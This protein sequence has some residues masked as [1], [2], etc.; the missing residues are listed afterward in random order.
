MLSNLD[1][2]G[3]P[4]RLEGEC[5]DKKFLPIVAR[6]KEGISRI[7]V[8][9][10]DF[11]CSNGK[12]PLK[13]VVGKTMHL[14]A[15]SDD[16]SKKRWF[17]GTCVSAEF[18]GGWDVG[19]HYR[20]EVCP[21]L[22]F[23][24]RRTDLRIFQELTVVD[25][26]QKVMQEHGFSGNLNAKLQQRYETR[27]YCTQYRETDF[28]F[29][30]RLMEEEGIYYY[31]E[32]DNGGTETMVLADIH[33]SHVPVAA[34]SELQFNNN[35]IRSTIE[36]T[37]PQVFEWNANEE[38]RSGKVTLRDFDFENISAD[39]EV[40]SA[41]KAGD[42]TR[43]DDNRY[44]YPG[45]YR[46]AS[47]G[48]KYAKIRMEADAIQHHVI[49]G[50]SDA[51]NLA[52][53]RTFKVNKL[54]RDSEPKDVMLIECHHDY[55]QLE[56]LDEAMKAAGGADALSTSGVSEDHEE[57]H[58]VRFKAIESDKQYRAPQTTRWPNIGGIHT[59]FVTGPAKE[60]I[61]TDKYGRIKVQFHWD[62]D[63]KEDENTSC[64]VRTMMPWT[65]KNWGAIAVP[66]IGQEVVIQ[67]EEGDPDRPLCIGMLYNDK[68]MPPYKLPDNKTQSGVKTNSSKGGGGFNELMFEDKKGDE[69]VRFQA[70][71]DY[72]Q[73]VKNNSTI[74]VG[75]EKKDPGNLKTT[76]HKNLSEIVKTGDHSTLVEMG[77]LDINVK[78]GK[79]TVK[80]MK[81]IEFKVGGSSIFMDPTSITVKSTMINVKGNAQVN[82]EG[83]ATTT[84]KAGG[85]L[86]LQGA[87]VKIN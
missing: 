73:I 22:W 10:V 1:P 62:L 78:M 29:I 25:I 36:R 59:A 47:L 21:W 68:M 33:S 2:S 16:A 4:L 14:V 6:V 43:A 67:F 75:L 82:V 38:I 76:V 30:S 86:T 87:L 31:F 15:E 56:A 24:T 85:I 60:E 81:S 39:L 23:L 27:T 46:V 58:M 40:E 71:K 53:G 57:P 55:V 19:G 65:G 13:E 50:L 51:V 52:V 84:V 83:G 34:P 70:E 12:L 54:V 7:P 35:M 80:A 20:A 77:D 48:E 69:L 66:R 11:F 44:D 18:M 17:R 42:Y 8:M 26:I 45:H 3:F 72:E 74:T 61:H 64:W 49:S 79:I 9:E 37:E 63:G 28:D 41:I 5:A 32:H